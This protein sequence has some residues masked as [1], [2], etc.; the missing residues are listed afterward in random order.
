[1]DKFGVEFEFAMNVIIQTHR[2]E[3]AEVVAYAVLESPMRKRRG[4]ALPR[5]EDIIVKYPTVAFIV[6]VKIAG[7]TEYVGFSD[8]AKESIEVVLHQI[9]ETKLYHLLPDM[10]K[11]NGLGRTALL[12]SL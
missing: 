4:H 10:K 2:P 3:D 5:R 1:M 7:R 8:G 12:S 11:H 9:E 6:K